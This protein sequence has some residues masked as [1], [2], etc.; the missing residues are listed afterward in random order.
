MFKGGC[1]KGRQRGAEYYTRNVSRLLQ[2]IFE[3]TCKLQTDLQ[4]GPL[5]STLP[6]TWS[7]ASCCYALG[8]TVT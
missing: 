3:P 7:I 8:Q 4:S 1:Q 2:K 5:A 6:E